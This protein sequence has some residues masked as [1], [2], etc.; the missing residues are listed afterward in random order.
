MDPGYSGFT[1]AQSARPP[2]LY[3]GAN[4]GMLHVFDDA[5]G[6]ETWAYVPT[7]L[8]RGATAGTALPPATNDP[9][10]GL[11]ALAYQDGALPAFRH[12]FYVDLTPKIVDA[13][14]SVPPD[15]SQWTTLLVG[16]MGKGGN[17]YFALNATNPTAVID[18]ATAGNQ[19]LWEFPPVG[20]AVT[21]MGYTYGKP[22]IAKTRVFNGE[23]LVIVGSGYN[24]PSG[25]GQ[26]VF[27][28][29]QHR[30]R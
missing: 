28:Q 1:S 20:D 8:Y 4:D 21:D 16:G 13:D 7:P 11:G 5:T 22:I 29:G 26:A 17:R 24:N 25:V 30:C 18:E 12:H 15:G 9:R 27:P 19:V 3:V 23:W 6:N 10:T 2:R 14:L